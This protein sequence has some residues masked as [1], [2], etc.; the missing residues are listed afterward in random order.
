M[1]RTYVTPTMEC[2][3]FAAD[4]YVAACYKINCNVPGYGDGYVESNGQA[5]LQTGRNGDNYKASGTGCGVMQTVVMEPGY[6]P[7]KGYW[8]VDGKIYDVTYFY[9][10]RYG[11]GS[12]S[13]HFSTVGYTSVANASGN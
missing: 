8:V 12:S 10:R 1:K 2:E 6:R 11:F 5:G 7:T 4:Q 13:H 3:S 9:A